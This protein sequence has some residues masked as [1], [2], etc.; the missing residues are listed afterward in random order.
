MSDFQEKYLPYHSK[1]P[2]CWLEVNQKH[3]TFLHIP[4]TTVLSIPKAHVDSSDLLE[5]MLF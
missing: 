3:F 2:F 5:Q 1:I 4:G